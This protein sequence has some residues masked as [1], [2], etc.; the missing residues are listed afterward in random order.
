MVTPPAVETGPRRYRAN[1]SHHQLP[2][3]NN[4]LYPSTAT[5]NHRQCLRCLAIAYFRHTLPGP[6]KFAAPGNSNGS[7]A[8]QLTSTHVTILYT[9][10]NVATTTVRKDLRLLC[11][12]GE[13]LTPLTTYSHSHNNKVSQDYKVS[14]DYPY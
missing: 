6:Q 12:T 8:V 4:Q 10:S 11:K 14:R 9:Y 3:E 13:P 5:N 2:V 7:G 1:R